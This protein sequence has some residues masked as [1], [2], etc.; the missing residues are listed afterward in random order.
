LFSVTES[1]AQRKKKKQSEVDEYFDE[2]GGWAHRLWFG[3][4][5]N[6]SFNSFNGNT[7][8]FLGISPM[9]GIR[10][11]ENDDRFSIGPRVSFEYSYRKFF[12]F[13]TN[14][15]EAV[16]PISYSFGAFAR[17]KVLPRIFPHVEIEVEN[18]GILVNSGNSVAVERLNRQ[19]YYIGAGYNS[20][21]L[22]GYEILVLYNINVPENSPQSPF[23][24]RVGFTYKF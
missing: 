24:I 9:M 3:G 18:R 2:S 17:Y 4:N 20:G 14:E 19:N 23:D 21:G 13:A 7:N 12:N 10:V 8:F 1:H 5:V 22:I 6:P 16:Q 11:F 15:F